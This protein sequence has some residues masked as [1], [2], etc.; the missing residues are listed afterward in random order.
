MDKIKNNNGK[1]I[2]LERF[3]HYNPCR[4]KNYGCPFNHY[5]N[6]KKIFV[7]CKEKK[8]NNKNL[9]HYDKPWLKKRCTNIECNKDHFY[10][11]EKWLKNK[12]KDFLEKKSLKSL[13]KDEK[14]IY[15]NPEVSKLLDNILVMINETNDKIKSDNILKT[16][17]IIIKKLLNINQNNNISDIIKYLKNKNSINNIDLKYRNKHIL[18]NKSKYKENFKVASYLTERI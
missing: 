17:E 7:N 16:L 18:E 13:N 12:K 4:Q 1:E 5:I 11:R 8:L 14:K 15:L 9:C 2:I 10:G 3:C 6:E